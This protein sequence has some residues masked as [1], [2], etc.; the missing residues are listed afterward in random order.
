MKRS[1]FITVKTEG[2][3]FTADF[4]QRLAS[5]SSDVPGLTPEA[6]HL[7]GRE[8]LNEAASRAWNRLLGI[9]AAFPDA[10][11]NIPVTEAATG[12]TREK[13]LLPLFNELGYGRLQSARAIELDDRTYPVSHTW[14]RVPIHLVG[15]NVELDRRTAGIVGAARINPH[16]LVQ[17][18]LN[19]RHESRWGFVSNGL[20]LRL[21]RDNRSL[22]RQAYVE[23]D[24]AAMMDGQ[25]FSDFVL[26]WL[27]C[28]ESRVE[29]E[30]SDDCW[31]EK[32]AKAS[33]EQATRALEDLRVGVEHA[34]EA[35]GR[36]FLRHPSNK[37]L[38][39]TLRAGTLD[40]QD[41]YRQLLRLVY[42]LI[43][44]FV[45]E[46]R[47]LLLV[48]EPSSAAAQRYSH[49]YSISRLRELAGRR[50]GT[51]HGD[52]W[53]ALA[54]VFRGLSSASG[55]GEL[56][57]PALG[58]LLWSDVATPD[59]DLC[60]L[61]NADL[62]DAI[63]ALAFRVDSG[64]RR[65]VDWRNMGSEELGS[66]YESLL[67][68]HPE[69]NTAGALFS[70]LVAA[71]HER[72]ETGSYY[73]PTSLVECLL[74]SALDPVL[75]EAAKSRDPERAV[76]SLK[77]CDPAVGSGHFLIAAGHRI[78][79]RLA[80]VRTG[81][82]EA[83]P[84]AVR[85]ALRD[86][87][88]HCLYG[89]DMNPMAVELCKVNLWLEAL[90]PGRPLSFLDHHIQC[91][92]SLL[93]AT[94]ALLR[95]GIPDAAFDPIEGDDREYCRD[96]KRWNKTERE[97]HQ[98]L[99]TTEPWERIG[100]LAIGMANLNEIDDSNLEGVREKEQRYAEIVRSAGYEQG[101]LLADAWC[102]AFVWPK[103][104]E[105]HP[106]SE[107]LFRAIER[108]PMAVAEPVR[109]QIR[110]FAEEYRFFHWH[111]AF[112]D[113]FR[114]PPAD[115]PV[116]EGPGWNG[117][118]DVLL[119]NPPWERIQPEALQF[120]AVAHPELLELKRKERTEAIERLAVSDPCLFAQ[121]TQQRHQDLGT[122]RFLK[123]S[124]RYPLSTTKNVNSYA[125]F[126]EL[127]L[128]LIGNR[129]YVG[130]VLQSGVATDAI[131]KMLFEHLVQGGALRSCYDFENRR[132]LFPGVDSRMKFCLLTLAGADV[133]RR[134]TTT[135]VF[136]AL[137]VSDLNQPDRRVELS[138]DQLRLLAPNTGLCP[139]FRSRRDAELVLALL[140]RTS[141][142]IIDGEPGRNDWAVTIRRIF[143]T[144]YDGGDF[145]N[146]LDGFPRETV[147]VVEDG[148]T[149]VRVFEA[150]LIHQF[151]H[152]FATYASADTCRNVSI[153]D[154]GP[155]VFTIPRSWGSQKELERRL[156]SLG[157]NHAYLIGY[158][159]VARAAD[160]R[161][162]IAAILP[163]TITDDTIRVIASNADDVSA[164]T[165]CSL[166]LSV[167]NSFVF[168]FGARNVVPSTH[169][170]E[171]LAKQLPVPA[172]TVFDQT[173]P[174]LGDG[175]SLREWILR[176]VV[177]L[178][179]TAYDLSGF[180]SDCDFP[181][182]PFQWNEERRFL[183]RCELDAMLFRL[184]LQPASGGQ[185]SRPAGEASRDLESLTAAFATPRHALVHMM[186]SFPIVQRKDEKKYGEYRTKR[187][188][189][190]IY[191]EMQCAIE[192]GQYKT[193]LSPP[194]A[195]ASCRH[196]KKKIGILAFG[197][198]IAD[199]GDELK[200]KIAMRVRTT[201]PFGVEYGR[202]SGKTRGGAPT[203]VPHVA[204]APV[205]A[206]ILVLDNAVTAA[207]AT[208]MLWRRET[209]KSGSDA[210]YG[211]GTSENSVL[212][213][214][215]IDNPWVETLLY[216]DF[217][218]AGKIPNPTAAELAEHAIRS[219]ES[220]K[221]GMDGISYLIAAISGGIQTPLASAYRE[222]ILRWTKADSLQDALVLA[223]NRVTTKA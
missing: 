46:A 144:S 54:V 180:A 56:G 53:E 36:G 133:P 7:A 104:R 146:F 162:A 120:F 35:L 64:V 95:A 182:P 30:V 59:L 142:W 149:Y 223:R 22:T 160:E 5:G 42:R 190:E 51:P 27:L 159:D 194:P 23:F 210:T 9:W 176:R 214:A 81:E 143:S 99:F 94:P 31:L 140:R 155:D 97:G 167:F 185:W 116:P 11:R 41:Y 107:D 216:T 161:T 156:A 70:L 93:G 164:A 200:P 25:A 148:S 105:A 34:I 8:K 188:I 125:V 98:N 39:E 15:F 119:G 79:R 58:S 193:M 43:F 12:V 198:L 106:I 154:R 163:R 157:W 89:V 145:V 18:L 29:G 111:L 150:K 189:L 96:L 130:L 114:V 73:T 90:E 1:A 68:L 177:E 174:W 65:L 172:P 102:A 221:P 13:W 123:D 24:L 124:E 108:N 84:D 206:E 129:G 20:K 121:W 181:G 153:V 168:D 183:L 101:N 208:N 75:A 113:V 2:G 49:Y 26:L 173:A 45:A 199:P 118:F 87:I 128:H 17:E 82:A 134:P 86:V 132:G 139:T 147:R 115:Q 85:H 37:A 209:R 72:K 165:S 10:T 61:G 14:Q 222:E 40:R 151:D 100:D 170:S 66:V 131:N 219:V 212:V 88:G 141:N 191:D 67:E 169:F 215:I 202:Y 83:S 184:Y 136:Y 16:G 126:A 117:G 50:R 197:S 74:D 38:A 60:K 62:L 192:A 47:D 112:P 186:D 57:L 91:G 201:T 92:N 138:S 166:L 122:T 211:E 175:L 171:Y 4:L 77:V 109:K 103:T 218:E 178:T 69:V 80:S 127:T 195:D 52:L 63:R 196:P 135:F 78:A 28:H 152:R 213:K 19:R 6:Y 71:G 32:W 203:L 110:S 217:P 44:L 3:L 48:A 205:A 137:A 33:R 158:R 55:S 76:L 21:L 187:L 204:G 207:E 179:F 220:A